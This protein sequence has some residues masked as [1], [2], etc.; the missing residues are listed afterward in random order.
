MNS[1]K[2]LFQCHFMYH[3]SHMGLPGMN[4]VLRGERPATNSFSHGTAGYQLR[5]LFDKIFS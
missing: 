1:D 3:I 5:K 2:I 4:P